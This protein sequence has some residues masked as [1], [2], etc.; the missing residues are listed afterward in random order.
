MRAQSEPG[1]GVLS[2]FFIA[3]GISAAG[4]MPPAIINLA[5]MNT[6][7]EHGLQ[8][9]F[10]FSAGAALTEAVL[11]RISMYGVEWIN[12]RAH[13]FKYIQGFVVLLLLLFAFGSFRSAMADPSAPK[14][15]GL[16]DA[17]PP[18]LFGMALRAIT[19]TLFPFWFATLSALAARGRLQPLNLHY[20]IFCVGLGIG[21]IVGHSI[22]IVGGV[23]AYQKMQAWGW[24]LH[25]IIGSLFL[26]AA[27]A[28][29]V[30]M[31]RKPK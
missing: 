23:L 19:P 26:L 24:V 7:V 28:M 20:S 22:Y 5:A 29:L 16:D 17:M 15:H 4:S 14:P 10:L 3:F 27:I 30:K 13:L 12:K 2:L 18:F 6:A 21:T 31:F 25:A 11:V 1:S 9:G 8:A